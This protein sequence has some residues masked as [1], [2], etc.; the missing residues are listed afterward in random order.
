M[1]K[2]QHEKMKKKPPRNE[3]VKTEQSFNTKEMIKNSKLKNIK[4]YY[5][6]LVYYLIRMFKSF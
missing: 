1:K 6:R 4:F 3:C 5:N 2:K